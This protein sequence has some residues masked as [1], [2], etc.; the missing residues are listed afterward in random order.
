MFGI[1][2]IVILGGS[3]LFVAMWAIYKSLSRSKSID[4]INALKVVIPYCKEQLL[5]NEVPYVVRELTDDSR[6]ITFR[7]LTSLDSNSLKSEYLKIL[8]GGAYDNHPCANARFRFLYYLIVC[9]TEIDHQIW[10]DKSEINVD[11]IDVDNAMMTLI[12]IEPETYA[13][14]PQYVVILHDAVHKYKDGKL[15]EIYGISFSNFWYGH[16]F[17]KNDDIENNTVALLREILM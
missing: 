10:A 12:N 7:E 9:I 8:Y 2:I 6:F 1:V 5:M 13:Q 17:T 14:L 3:P 4:Y 11:T 16:K 15:Q